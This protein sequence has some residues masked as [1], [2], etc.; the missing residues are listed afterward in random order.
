M[1]IGVSSDWKAINSTVKILDAMHCHRGGEFLFPLNFQNVDWN[2][3]EGAIRTEDAESKV[4]R[5]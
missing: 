4:G 5:R 3:V 1:D 2:E